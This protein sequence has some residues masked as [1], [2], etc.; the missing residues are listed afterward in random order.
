VTASDTQNQYE[1]RIYQVSTAIAVTGPTGSI[2]VTLPALTGFTFNIYIGTTTSPANLATTI[3]GPVSGPFQG[4]ATQL[5]PNQVVVLTNA[6]VAQTPPAAPATGVTVYPT[7][8]FGRGA[9]GQVKL[10]DIKT[11]FLTGPDKS[12]P[13]NQLRVIGWK[14]FYGTIIL[15]QQFFCRVE[16]SSAF[17]STFG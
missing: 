11:T 14:V 6:G 17:T 16:S 10:E 13:L 7:F 5:A 8:F 15:N 4:Q 2:S 9:Y 12:D 1:S 3:A